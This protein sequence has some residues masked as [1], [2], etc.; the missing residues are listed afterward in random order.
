MNQHRSSSLAPW[1]IYVLGG[2]F[3]TYTFFQRTNPSA[4]VESLMRDF[5]V[6]AA[7]LGNLSAVYFYAYAAMQIP[8][9]V[10]FDRWGTRWIL[11][12]AALVSAGGAV[13]FALAPNLDIAIVGRVLVGL[14][15]GMSYLGALALAMIW[16]PRER[17]ALLVGISMPFGIVG[18]VLGQAPF[19]A[20]LQVVDWRD[21]ILGS[22]G[23]ALLLALMF[24]L[25]RS[26]KPPAN[27]AQSASAEAGAKRPAL[28][29][30]LRR[31]ARE[32][33]TWVLSLSGA[34]SV[35]PMFSFAGLWAVPYLMQVHGLERPAAA[36]AASL[37]LIGLGIGSILSG[38]LSNRLRRRKALFVAG[39]VVSLAGWLVVVLVPDLPI[40]VHCLLYLL[41]GIA[42]G[43]SVLTYIA[44]QDH[45]G[46]ATSGAGSAIINTFYLGGGAFAQYFIGM[47][48][49]L[50]W[51]GD[52]VAG[53]RIYPAVA[54]D[55]ALLAMPASVGI[56]FALS[57]AIRE[58]HPGRDPGG[59]M[60]L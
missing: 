31:A 17:Y 20:L 58:S 47:L 13:L 21:A 51:A 23:L 19:A 56:A 5:D 7:A 6:N 53:V 2:S 12:L 45:A 30:S 32:P 44:A 29:D 46:A 8:A 36:G 39:L 24:W 11:A 3:F 1:L 28:L 59:S 4:M 10:I 40:A 18:G 54:Y 42:K 48:L 27:A 35:A 22:A 55:A 15:G 41:I 33:Q 49:D 14:S 25:S 50:H 57:F 26:A 43:A 38:W 37:M 34:F 60:P 9:G 52:L 16:F